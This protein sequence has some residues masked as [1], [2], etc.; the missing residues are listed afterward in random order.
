MTTFWL[1]FGRLGHCEATAADVAGTAGR[2]L[3]HLLDGLFPV[4]ATFLPHVVA[5][6]AQQDAVV[7]VVPKFWRVYPGDDVMDVQR[8]NLR[9]ATLTDSRVSLPNGA[10]KPL[11]SVALPVAGACPSTPV[12][13]VGAG[14][15]TQPNLSELRPRSSGQLTTES[16]GLV[17]GVVRL[18]ADGNSRQSF[19]PRFGSLESQHRIVADVSFSS[20]SADVGQLRWVVV[21][22]AP[23]G[24]AQSRTERAAVSPPLEM[25]PALEAISVH[26]SLRRHYP[27]IPNARKDVKCL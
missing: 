23:T 21:D 6:N 5:L 7:G 11:V 1:N 17:S 24:R 14:E 16:F 12:E 27:I 4:W 8:A 18:E 10:K 26:V 19:C 2:K 13:V 3:A 25:L 20:G 22:V 9:S 15:L